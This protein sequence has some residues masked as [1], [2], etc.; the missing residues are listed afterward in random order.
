[1]APS[2][3]VNNID[4]VAIAATVSITNTGRAI[5]RD[6]YLGLWA[7]PPGPNC[8][9]MFGSVN[10]DRWERYD[11]LNFWNV[12]SRE[13]IRVAPGAPA[14]VG[15]FELFLKPPF[16]KPYSFSASA[17]CEGGERWEDRT[18][19]PPEQLLDIY[20]K[21][22]L[23]VRTGTSASGVYDAVLTGKA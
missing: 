16:L 2:L 6:I 18:D 12:I 1:L 23:S 13:G 7:Y 17:G 20:N 8:G 5:A 21:A 9:V 14:P 22:L 19:I 4:V 10:P 15:V 3:T 11:L